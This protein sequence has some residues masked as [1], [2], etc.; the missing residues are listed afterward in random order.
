VASE[1]ALRSAPLFGC[2][3]ALHSPT[4]SIYTLFAQ[5]P[6]PI[7]SQEAR[8]H[9]RIPYAIIALRLG[10]HT[11]PGEKPA[12]SSTW[13]CL[14]TS[15]ETFISRPHRE[16]KQPQL[17]PSL[18]KPKSDQGILCFKQ[19]VGALRRDSGIATDISYTASPVPRAI[20]VTRL[21]ESSP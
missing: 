1:T 20:T 4:P 10:A 7:S 9:L 11:F 15:E 19:G 13:L 6:S 14:E 5:I 3:F 18:Y 2:A 21:S 16:K 17:L 12:K 8:H